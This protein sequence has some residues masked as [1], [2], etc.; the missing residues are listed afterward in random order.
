MIIINIGNTT[1]K[2]CSS[3]GFLQELCS[4][5]RNIVSFSR[6]S[7]SHQHCN[8]PAKSHITQPVH[9]SRTLVHHSRTPV[10]HSRT[11]V[12]IAYHNLIIN[13]NVWMDLSHQVKTIA[14]I[15]IFCLSNITTINFDIL[16]RKNG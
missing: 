5:E 14:T 12:H 13:N 7:L 6:L 9:H 10:H 15:N 2:D 1:I 4:T 8:G 3:K 16:S 11:L